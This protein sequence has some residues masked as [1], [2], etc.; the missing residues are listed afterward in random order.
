MFSELPARLFVPEPLGVHGPSSAIPGLAILVRTD[1]AR[2]A[3]AIIFMVM[4]SPFLR[5]E[6]RYVSCTGLM[7]LDLMQLGSPRNSLDGLAT[8]G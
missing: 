3:A 4:S 5:L 7:A 2:R 8:P 6:P 1:T